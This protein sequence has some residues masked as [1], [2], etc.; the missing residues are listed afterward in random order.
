[1]KDYVPIDS[2]EPI[3]AV[4]NDRDDDDLAAVD[5][6]AV[7]VT[8][9]ELRRRL[10]P[11]RVRAFVL[12]ERASETAW[13][14]EAA[15]PLLPWDADRAE[16]VAGQLGGAVVLTYSTPTPA[17]GQIMDDL[18]KRG[19]TVQEIAT[20]PTTPDPLVLATRLVEPLV[21]ERRAEYLRI[22]GVLPAEGGYAVSLLSGPASGEF[23]GPIETMASRV[24]LA[25]V[26]V[27]GDAA[28]IDLLAMVAGASL[29]VSDSPSM[30]DLAAGFQRPALGVAPP[31]SD[32]RQWPAFGAESLAFEPDHLPEMAQRLLDPAHEPGL[33][34]RLIRDAHLFFDDLSQGL[35][36]SCADEVVQT[37]AQRLADLAEQ[38]SALE[39]VNAGLRECLAREREAMAAHV[40]SLR[41]PG[42][43]DSAESRAA[44]KAAE[45]EIERLRA[46]NERLDAE[47]RSIYA[48][49]TMRALGPARHLYAR[50]RSITP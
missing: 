42:E 36:N 12:S 40:K 2:A 22:V 27:R 8:I 16:R 11:V 20:G 15:Q 26:T 14:D 18:T 49:R 43:S 10:A 24:G 38:S 30:V 46:K 47:I 5:R 17:A 13:A 7:A 21:L 37:A 35:A 50:L 28:P 39:L 19:R 4:V 44:L 1:M 23:T 32:E 48:T 3:V 31:S 6:L 33:G 34:D 25:V 9:A 29:V 45:A 41:E